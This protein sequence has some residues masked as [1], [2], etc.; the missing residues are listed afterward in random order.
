MYQQMYSRAPLLFLIFS[1]FTRLSLSL[2]NAW[3]GTI[4][5]L[6]IP[7]I[8]GIGFLFDLRPVLLFTLCFALISKCT[9]S[10]IKNW[11]EK[12]PI[13]EWFGFM[14]V[15]F[16]L[17]FQMFAEW[18]FWGDMDCRFNFI[19]IDYLIYTHEVVNNIMQSYP[20]KTYLAIMLG[21][22]GLGG[23]YLKRFPKAPVAYDL[24]T[25]TKIACFLVFSFLLPIEHWSK[26]N[27]SKN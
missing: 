11:T 6:E 17:S 26:N 7:A 21:I 24:K 23:Y 10:F 19:A 2:Y 14:I 13:L 16:L 12:R 25:T 15:L 3:I 27:F 4:S 18:I 5:W 8:L 9:P 20:I 22:A 1:N